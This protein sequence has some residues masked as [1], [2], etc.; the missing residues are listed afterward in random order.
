MYIVFII[1]YIPDIF[2]SKQ[3]ELLDFQ[4]FL[5]NNF[6]WEIGYSVRVT[7]IRLLAQTLFYLFLQLTRGITINQ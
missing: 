4:T 2:F 6:T 5:K 3:L 1:I 7:N